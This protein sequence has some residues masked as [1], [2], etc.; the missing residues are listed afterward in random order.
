M[1]HTMC[2]LLAVLL[3]LVLLLA[4]CADKETTWQEQYDLGV[5]YLSEGNYDEAILAFQ[6]AIE[7]DPKN[8][9]AYIGVGDAYAG[10]AAQSNDAAEKQEYLLNAKDWYEQAKDLGDESAQD[11]IGQIIEEE[12]NTTEG[13]S[14]QSGQHLPENFLQ[15]WEYS[16]TGVIEEVWA[17]SSVTLCVPDGRVLQTNYYLYDEFGRLV[18]EEYEF[19]NF[20]TEQ[21]EARPATIWKED[22]E[23]GEWCQVDQWYE[24]GNMREQIIIEDA[25]VE[26]AGEAPM[27]R[28]QY[29]NINAYFSDFP[30]GSTKAFYYNAYGDDGYKLEDIREYFL[31]GAEVEYSFDSNGNVSRVNLYDGTGALHSY[32][33]LKF[34]KVSALM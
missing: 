16:R 15:E 32:A 9:Q 2:K 14:T 1:K 23:T 30:T 26:V 21:E 11:K 4:G 34:K 33:E 5:R 28:T 6:A 25:W 3:C 13:S 27:E 18:R 12:D 10:L 22:L 24:D 17:I 20:E 29:A 19:V 31:P 8:A 7:I